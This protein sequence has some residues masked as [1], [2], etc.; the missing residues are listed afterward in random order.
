NEVFV[1]LFVQNLVEY[2]IV[3]RRDS[4]GTVKTSAVERPLRQA[5]LLDFKKKYRAGGTA[6]GAKLD[7]GPSEGMASLNRELNPAELNDDQQKFI[8]NSASQLFNSLQLAGSV[9]IDFLAD[10]E[11]GELWLNEANTIPG[12][13]AYFLWEAA[14]TPI[15]FLALTS[16]IVE[17][18]FALSNNRLGETTADAGGANIFA[19]G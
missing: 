5:A 16:A 17:E 11:T 2:N 9:R 18:G 13:F 1:D 7:T 3:C 6:G 10:S 4:A 14:E 12:S 19:R 15:S 8:K